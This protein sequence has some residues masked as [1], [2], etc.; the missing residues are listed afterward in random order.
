MEENYTETAIEQHVQVAD[1]KISTK[2][3]FWQNGLSIDE[4]K[5]SA[6]ILCL[7]GCLIFG[8]IN[9]ST[10][11]DIS[12]NLTTIITALIYSIAG[13]NITNSIVNRVSTTRASE[14]HPYMVQTTMPT[15]MPAPIQSNQAVYM[16]E[17]KMTTAN[18]AANPNA[19]K[20]QVG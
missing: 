20:P 17:T 7:I 12:T 8:G 9:Y 5:L 11:G 15:T 16:Q 19:N 10:I 1:Q 13:V 4:T 18:K 3:W 2:K 14:A 6:L